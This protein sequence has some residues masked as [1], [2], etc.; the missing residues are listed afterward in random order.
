MVKI[1]KKNSVRNIGVSVEKDIPITLQC[2]TD[3]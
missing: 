2:V 1:Y 3:S